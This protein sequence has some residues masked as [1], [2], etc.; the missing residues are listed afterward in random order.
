[1]ILPNSKN[2]SFP[3][4]LHQLL[5][6]YSGKVAALRGQRVI[7]SA[8]LVQLTKSLA[9]LAERQATDDTQA[10][11]FEK[12]SVKKWLMFREAPKKSY[13]KWGH[14]KWKNA[15]SII[16]QQQWFQW[17]FWE[18]SGFFITLRDVESESS[19]IV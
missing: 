18:V 15:A 7:Y 8:Q 5:H 12:L 17:Q 16:E 4:L 19:V 9:Y 13:L 6:G 11:I 3:V 2:V 14:F 10:T 1:M